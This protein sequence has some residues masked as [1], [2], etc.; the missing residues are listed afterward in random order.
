MRPLLTTQNPQLSFVLTVVKMRKE[1]DK[2]NPGAFEH[3]P[4]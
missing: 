4:G 2:D 1:Y 3:G